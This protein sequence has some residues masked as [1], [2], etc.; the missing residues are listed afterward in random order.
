MKLY[1]LSYPNLDL[2][3]IIDEIGQPS[4]PIRYL[5][6]Y[7]DNIVWNGNMV[8]ELLSGLRY[9]HIFTRRFLHY[10]GGERQ[11]IIVNKANA[12][13]RIW[14]QEPTSDVDFLIINAEDSNGP[15]MQNYAPAPGQAGFAVSWNGTNF[16]VQD[17]PN[18]P[19]TELSSY[20]FESAKKME[21][22]GNPW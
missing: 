15:K 2:G 14:C 13:F 18:I 7:T 16:V 4:S 19:F 3:S 5:H 17:K 9:V 10:D 20:G 21:H 6:L 22:F 1:V 12:I 8:S 11:V